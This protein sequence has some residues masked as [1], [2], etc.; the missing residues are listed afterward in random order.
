M[1]P[2]AASTLLAL[3]ACSGDTSDTGVAIDQD[4]GPA[5]SVDAPAPTLRRL[6]W[7]QYEQTVQ[8]LLGDDLALPTR[9]EPD[10]RIDGLPSVGATVM[11]L[12]AWGVERYEDA[13]FLLAEQALLDDRILVCDPASETDADCAAEI[14]DTWGLRLY[15]RP[16]TVDEATPLTDLVLSVAGAESDFRVGAT[17]G[18]A[19]MLQSPHFLYRVELGTPDATDPELRWLDD[20]ELATRLSYLLWN[21]TPDDTLLQ[22]AAEGRLN[23]DD[24]LLDEATRLLEDPRADQGVRNLF[25]E[26]LHLDELDDLSKDPTTFTHAS[27]D[28]GPN[29]REETLLGVLDLVLTQD[30]DYRDLY[31]TRETWVD[32]SLAALYNVEAPVMDGFGQVTLDKVDGRRGLLGQASFLALNAHLTSTSATLRGKF[33]Q[34]VVLCH[35]IP[36][37]PSGVDTSVPEADAES[38]T[39]RERIASHLED[40]TCATCHELTDLVGLGFENFDGVGRWRD[41]ENDAVIDPSGELEGVP[42]GDAWDFA[43]VLREHPDLGP[44]LSE[45]VWGVG[46]GHAPTYGEL[47][48]SEWLADEL[49]VYGYSVKRLLL[50]TVTS[51]GFRQTGAIE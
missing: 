28:L 6:T 45:H 30:G 20:Y 26:I 32:R 36:P 29:A 21:T 48:L 1:T 38:P 19:A 47:A 11:S 44:C 17:Y 43:G 37:P 2:I 40:P 50:A 15:R 23:T 25:T 39:L 35:T 27:A 3:V 51:D 46:T 7:A 18:L 8:D 16:L 4:H 22:A 24:G 12:S 33:I 14:I 34:E 9:L 42:F 49:A 5:P 10:T 31:T 41:T 13:A